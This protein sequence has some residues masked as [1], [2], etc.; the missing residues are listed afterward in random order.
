MSYLSNTG[1]ITCV[2]TKTKIRPVR[3]FS[4]SG[5]HHRE[6][7]FIRQELRTTLNHVALEPLFP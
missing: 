1:V 6:I 2:V 7:I 4:N 5:T 3:H